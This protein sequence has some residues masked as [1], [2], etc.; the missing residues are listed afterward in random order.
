MKILRLDLRAFGPFT[1]EVLDLSGGHEGLHLILGPNEA[2]KSSALRALRQM[3]FGIDQ[4]TN[5]NFL[6]DY[7]NLC[8][9]CTLRDPQ[10]DELRFLRIKRQSKTLLNPDT[11]TA[12]DDAVLARVLGGLTEEK[13]LS[14]FSLDHETLVSGGR[15]IAAGKGSVAELIFGAGSDLSRLRKLQQKLDSEHGNLFKGRGSVPPLNKSFQELA[16]ARSSIEDASLKSADW[17]AQNQLRHDSARLKSELDARLQQRRREAKRLERI[18]LALSDISARRDCLSK[19]ESLSDAPRLRDNFSDRYTR[20]RDQLQSARITLDHAEK[21]AQRLSEVIENL[22]PPGPILAQSDL[23]TDFSQRLASLRSRAAE[24]L[25]VETDRKH[26]EARVLRALRDLNRPM[27]LDQAEDLRLPAAQRERIRRLEQ[28]GRELLHECRESHQ[29]IDRKLAEAADLRRQ[30]DTL[31]APVETSALASA[32][33]PARTSGD[34]EDQLKS[35][36]ASLARR[37][38]QSLSALDRLNP[39]I[40]ALDDLAALPIPA[41]ATIQTHQE[42]LESAT[43]LEQKARDQLAEADEQHAQTR[44]LL[45]ARQDE[46][47]VPSLDDLTALRTQRDALWLR[48]E[49][50]WNDPPASPDPRLADEFRQALAA[51]D[52]LADLRFTQADRLAQIDRLQA[53]LR[54]QEALCNS[55]RL[56][57]DQSV[58]QREDAESAWKT[59]WSPLG[60]DPL[61]PREMLA[62][63]RDFEKLAEKRDELRLETDQL[64][65]DAQ[66]LDDLR[67]SLSSALAS[68]GIPAPS[69][70]RPLADL[71]DLAQSFLEDEKQRSRDRKRLSDDLNRTDRE[72]ET[73]RAEENESLRQHEQWKTA[74]TEALQPLGLDAQTDGSE[75]ITI[76]DLIQTTLRDYDQLGQL[77]QQID[78]HQR[79]QSRLETESR[80]L[81]A[82][83]APELA[84]EPLEHRLSALSEH[85]RLAS[86]A[87]LRR[88]NLAQALETQQTKASDA[89]QA[90]DL[91]R[92]QL[93]ELAREAGASSIDDI[94]RAEEN[95]RL[96]A[97]AEA[98]R[99]A[100]E[101]RLRNLCAGQDLAD[102]LAEAEQE[103]P[104][105]DS[106]EA[107]RLSIE[108]EIDQLRDQRDAAASDETEARVRLEQ[109]DETARDAAAYQ[110]AVEKEHI[111]ARIDSL[112]Q[113][114]LRTRLASGLLRRAVEDYRSRSQAPVLKR[115]SALFAALTCGSFSS[116]DTELDDHDQ[117][118]IVGVRPSGERLTVSQMSEGTCDQLY[119]ALKLASLEHDLD[120]GSAFPFVADDILVNFDDQ[121]AGAALR[122][123]ADLSR[124]T[125][126]LFFTH[127][128]HLV[129]LAENV[130][131]PDVLF[132]RELRRP[133]AVAAG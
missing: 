19:L 118:L 35:A 78:N 10:G 34:L 84:D 71:C 108:S 30:L 47:P 97:D 64:E 86:E 31:P 53:D 107:I 79:A 12:L 89:R 76:L 127:H 43:R 13:Y 91:A 17:E 27:S 109:M 32:L 5:D 60:F 62:W 9:G 73:L 48:I 90:L 106:L 92:A 132:I 119:L 101:T 67:A 15:E 28:S 133:L 61:T 38:R 59:L 40:R 123:L 14:L 128:E 68:V 72:L 29:S 81:V 45:T 4:R 87:Q 36:R 69:L 63:H 23:I 7:K 126:V 124:R 22:G 102:F 113:N 49:T 42:S 121:R 70:A 120:H 20:A 100:I 99:L 33:K 8:V 44:A 21:E 83:L 18:D 122:V 2:G 56:L 116:L 39:P 1:D 16:A 105:A 112:T 50:A 58:K 94:P 65:D 130:L 46:R 82:W 3:L 129:R 51:A 95:A 114:Y 88:E 66:R 115:S 37:E 96:R 57:L 110:A 24:I 80:E 77:R 25:Q 26:L 6:H 125:Q 131:P 103:I 75:A 111:L 104:R 54:Q 85:L 117:P 98:E 93:E 11:E 74:W 52:D 41:P 55:R